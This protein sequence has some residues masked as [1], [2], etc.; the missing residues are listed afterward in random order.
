MPR[1]RPK[2]DINHREIA[3]AFAGCGCTVMD[4]AGEGGGIPDLMVGAN[5]KW[6]G[7]E[8]KQ[9]GEHLRQNQQ[10]YFDAARGPC[11]VV[12]DLNEVHAVR[13]WFVDG[14]E[15]KGVYHNLDLQPVRILQR[16]NSA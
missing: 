13:Q 16:C 6:A 2:K 5:G 3:K 7:V 1:T 9:P 4:L 10:Q 14:K 12:H 11:F 15:P 8:I